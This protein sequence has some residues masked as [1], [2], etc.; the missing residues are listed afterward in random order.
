MPVICGLLKSK[1][2]YNVAEKET[3]NKVVS[4][5]KAKKTKSP[6]PEEEMERPIDSTKIMTEPLPRILD[7][8]DNSV[9]S[10]HEAAKDARKAAEEARQAGE[11]AVTEAARVAAEAIARVEQVAQDAL[12][13]AELL[14]SA[15][16]EAAAGLQKRL[17]EKS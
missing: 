16:T 4:E 6:Q 1:V 9:R 14:E 2:C 8:I 10:A 13:L 11:K 17:S 5:N 7:E 12:R 3:K 15:V